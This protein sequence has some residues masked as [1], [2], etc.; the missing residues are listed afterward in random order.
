MG[1]KTQVAHNLIIM[2]TIEIKASKRESLGRKNAVTLRREGQVPC[3]IY[4]GTEI[5]HFYAHEFEFKKLIFTPNVYLVSLNIDGTK[6]NCV[7]QD[8]QYHPLSDKLVHADFLSI[9]ADKPVNIKIPVKLVGIAE[10]AKQ[11]GKLVQKMRLMKVSGLSKDLPNVLEI[12]V[13]KV[14][15]GQSIKVEKLSFPNLQIL[16]PK[17]AIVCVISMTRSA[18]KEMEGKK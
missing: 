14:G 18:M 6:Y 2:E 10:G 8:T 3:V 16:E 17:N 13:T 15:I 12:D 5:V 4:G 11:G 9:T 1:G 7:L